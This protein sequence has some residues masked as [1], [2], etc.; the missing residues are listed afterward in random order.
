M[1]TCP[2]CSNDFARQFLLLTSN[3]WNRKRPS[4]NYVLRTCKFSVIHV[5]GHAQLRHARTH[6]HTHTH[7]LTHTQTH[8]H[9]HTH[10]HSVTQTHTHTHTLSHTHTQTHS[11]AHTHSLTHTHTHTLTQTHTLTH[12]QSLSEDSE[13]LVTKSLFAD[14]TVWRVLF[15]PDKSLS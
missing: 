7:S 10:T 5:R 11:H 13:P 6:T 15:R 1:M 2:E 4:V 9:T 14:E 8:S 12:T 3:C